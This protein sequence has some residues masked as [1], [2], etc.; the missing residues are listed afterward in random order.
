MT[1]H[2]YATPVLVQN[3]LASPLHR[4]EFDDNFRDEDWLQQLLFEHPELIPFDEIEPAFKGSVAVAREVESGSG[5]IDM[6][7]VNGDGLLTLVETKLWRNPESRR[8]VVS[9]LINYAAELAK[10]SYENLIQ[11]L[12][13]AEEEDGDLLVRQI[14]ASAASFDKR[15]FI[16]AVSLNLKRGRFLLLIVGDG[17]REDV[18]SMAEFLQG[19]PNL[20]FTLGL[21]EMALFRLKEGSNDA[22]LV[23]PRIV[24]RTREV[25]RA[26]IEIRGG[27]LVVSTPPEPSK[28][29]PAERYTITEDQF[30]GELANAVKPETIAFARRM[31]EHAPERGLSVDWKQAGPVFKYVDADRGTF[32]TL[33]QFH[34]DGSLCELSRFQDR[35]EKLELPDDIWENYFDA[36]VRL[37]PGASRKHFRS[38]AGNE[39]DDVVFN[40]GAH[41]LDSLAAR[42]DEWLAAVDSATKEVREA[43][44]NQ[45]MK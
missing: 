13:D 15:R 28:G 26:I 3:N 34:R 29:L 19:K 31:V 38:K 40:D 27:E 17:I 10:L 32:F 8:T 33:C 42:R 41:P 4:V 20:G 6:V 1:N 21:V 24:A 22:I 23:Q 7:Y 36:T 30:F 39:W 18:D 16:D 5:P 2:T 9:Q 35:C 44:E 43:L 25:K 37:I 14:E 11:A 45:A 12:A